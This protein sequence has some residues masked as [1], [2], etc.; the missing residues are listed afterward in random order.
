MTSRF[1][2]AA[3]AAVLFAVPSFAAP[4]PNG[5]GKLPALT[6]QTQPVSKL[7]LSLRSAVKAVAG[8][9]PV[10][11]MDEAIKE[12]LGE[13]GFT[14]LDLTKPILAY[15][16]LDD[17]AATSSGFVLVPTTGE[18]EFK[19]FTGRFLKEKAVKFNPVENHKGLYKVEPTDEDNAAD[20]SI[21]MR[22][23]NGYA[24]FGI[25]VKPEEMAEKVLVVPGVLTDPKDTALIS[26]RMHF[27]S[28]PDALRKKAF[29]KL[30]E[31]VNE[32]TGEAARVV[33]MDLFRVGVVANEAG[34][35]QKK[36]AKAMAGM[37]KRRGN[38]VLSEADWAGYALRYDDRTAEMAFEGVLTPKAGTP[39]AKEIAARKPHENQ[40]AGLVSKEAAVGITV[41][42]PLFEAEIRDV[43]AGAVA[44][45]QRKM[46]DESPA[47]EEFQPIVEELFAGAQRTVKSGTFD[48][49]AALVGPNKEGQFDTAIA[50]SYDDAPKLEKE[51]KALAKKKVP[52]EFLKSV[53][54]DKVKVGEVGV[55]E[56]DA[57]IIPEEMKKGVP[58]FP[59]GNLYL[60]FAPKA[61]Y[62]TFGPSGLQ[63]MKDLLAAKPAPA[64]AFDVTLNP[65]RLQKLVALYEPNV[66]QMLPD[67][68][69]SEDAA[70][71]V[72]FAEVAGGDALRV[73]FGLNLKTSIAP[74]TKLGERSER[75]F[76]QLEQEL[77]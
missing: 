28:I 43:L 17:D 53:K 15:G 33:P 40:F 10:K 71:S 19:A 14:G 58:N 50:I 1:L 23:A 51:V 56:I 55:H 42:A 75:R 5:K 29:D 72:V 25:N 4:L 63:T 37:V 7:M 68:F 13:K 34:E 54:F 69:G 2:S 67:F 38:Q 36:S 73:R 64:R 49:A 61:V 18:E 20:V 76:N 6:G 47:P 22:V 16:E 8:E 12:A 21:Y 66:A 74:I 30:D 27:D 35:F 44:E 3:F 32:I 48:F 24:Y 45:A 11:K 60:A 39:L 46:K 62:V 31:L 52:E 57:A 41:S 70:S 9:E 59:A 26:Y 65:A 77:K